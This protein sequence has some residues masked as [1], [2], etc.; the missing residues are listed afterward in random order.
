MSAP[1]YLT[2]NELPVGTTG[3]YEF[4]FAGGYLEKSHVRLDFVTEVG[5]RVNYPITEGMF[6]TEFTIQIPFADIPAGTASMRI[7][8]ETPR[9]APLLNFS[10]GSRLTERNLDRLAQQTIFV[11]AEAFDAGAFAVA[12]DLIGQALTAIEQTQALIDQA[13]GIVDTAA[14]SASVANAAQLA[15]SG[16]AT[17]AA[18]SATSAASS[19]TTALTQAGLAIAAR[20]AAALS[21]SAAA[22]SASAAAG[23]A[24]S[25]A[26]SAQSALNAATAAALSFDSFDDRYLGAKATSPTAD[27]DG[28]P[29]LVGALYFN[30]I[31]NQMY[32]WNGG[33]W[34]VTAGNVSLP[35]S[36]ANG[37]TG[38]TSAVAAFDALKLPASETFDGTLRLATP[39]EALAGTAGAAAMTPNTLRAGLNASGTAPIYACRAWAHFNGA[40]VG[41]VTLLGT[42]NITSIT[43]VA[44]G[45]YDVVFATAL[46]VSGYAVAGSA[47][48]VGTPYAGVIGSGMG[49]TKT[50]TGFRLH[51]FNFA[52]SLTDYTNI[53]IQVFC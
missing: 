39:A 32:V 40:G 16:S 27:N 25:A 50:T 45:V 13:Q 35:V 14:N 8:R 43:R 49:G 22:G 12:E 6:V 4:S 20:D 19:A 30:S 23:S 2:I 5:A 24:T 15:A 47:F 53:S 26:Q 21:A 52:S 10:T 33:S 1:E 51:A 46:P 34:G 36:I 3:L 17:A 44:P 42:G 28:A 18:G 7:Y 31:L 38:Q 41:G 37:G 29:L 48:S 9:D 11:A